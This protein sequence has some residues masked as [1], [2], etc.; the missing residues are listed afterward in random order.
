MPIA[1]LP[2]DIIEHYNLLE[3]A[4]DGYVYMEICKGMYGLPQ[5][6]VLANKLLARHGYF[7]QPH[8]LGL[9]KHRS[10]PVLFNLCVDGFGIKYIGTENLQHL[11]DAL[12][13]ETYEIVEDWEGNLYYCGITLKWNYTKQYV[14]LSMA[15]Y[16]TKQLTQ[17]GHIPFLKP[18][19]C[20]Y[21]PNPINYGKDNHSPSPIDDSPLLDDVGKK[22]I[23]RIIDSFL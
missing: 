11:Y 23:Q 7:K 10:Q 6:G 9:W 19:H 21:A 16:V 15:A 2:T 12:Q 3:K 13:T 20:P 4:I 14:N 17:Y 8:T 1:L 5:A 18:Q 22:Q